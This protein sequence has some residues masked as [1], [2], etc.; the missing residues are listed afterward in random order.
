LAAYERPFKRTTDSEHALPVAPN[1]I[2][3]DFAADGPDRKWGADIS[4][5]WTAEGWLYLAIVLVLFYRRVVGSATFHNH[6]RL[7]TAH[8]RQLPAVVKF[9][10]IE[11]DQQVQAVA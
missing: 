2:A 11:T 3:Q 4:Y 10:A 8:G 7:H 9:N 1:R 5:I 6:Q